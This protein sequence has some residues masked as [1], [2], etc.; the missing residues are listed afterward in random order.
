MAGPSDLTHSLEWLSTNFPC[1]AAC[2]VGTNAGGYVSLISEGRFEDA[3]LLARRPNPLASVCGWICAHPCESAC[4]RA[5]VD[6]AISIRALKRFA[7][8]RFGVESA[9]KFDEILEVVERPR[10]PAEEPG[11]VAVVGAGPAGLACAHDLALM[12]HEV[13]VFESAAAAGGM[14]RFGIPPYRLPREI[15]DCEVDFIAY[16]GVEFRFETEVGRDVSFDDLLADHDAVF[17][18]PG[19][20]KGKGLPIPGADL[21]GVITAVDLLAAVNIGNPLDIGERVVVVGGGNVA[22]D[23]A[24][25]VRLFGGT[26]VPEEEHHRL[27]VDAAMV[28]SRT[29]SRDVTMISLEARDEL[30]ADPEEIEAAEEEGIQLIHR[31][32]PQAVLAG[33]DG[34]ARALRTIDVSRVFDEE[35]RFAPEFVE[36]T[37]QEIEADTV[38]L[39]IGQVADLSFL[40]EDPGL[41]VTPQSTISV[42]RETLASSNPKVFA[43]G[44]VAFGPRIAI[45]AVAEGRRA[46]KAIDTRITGRED[47][48]GAYRVRILDTF[49]YDHPFARGDYEA[50]PRGRMPTVPAERRTFKEPVELPYEEEQARLEGSRCLR[51]WINT[52]IDSRA[53]DGAECIQC[54][55][56]V[57]V[58]PTDCFDLVTLARI[59]SES[60]G[61]EPLRLP[62]GS[63]FRPLLDLDTGAALL[64]DETA[65]IR[66]GLCARRCPVQCITMR[67]FYREEEAEVMRTAEATV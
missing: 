30:P 33:S 8:E 2:P 24:R 65:C 23:V 29:L 55:G 60:D 66:C 56:C 15:I 11:R 47:E 9:R 50:V 16:L 57:D 39:A 1:R 36:G 61:P 6:Q 28:A 25:S 5:S 59:A 32:G 37:E 19:C 26:S 44:D 52:V 27:L 58:C 38:V 35:G 17:L 13:T 51:C 63:P 40:G 20:R 10:P 34:R 14:L 64:K 31:R 54:A 43:G 41:E 7:C 22:S 21:P 62:D 4:R 42:A 67:G 3:Y 46:A 45:E 12:G 48:P 18:A 49:G 53:L